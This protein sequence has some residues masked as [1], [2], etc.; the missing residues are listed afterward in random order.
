VL[1]AR[2]AA[3]ALVAVC[4]PF[5]RAQY[6]PANPDWNRPIEPFRIV[7]GLYYVGVQDVSSFL[8]TTQ[9]GHI[10]LDGAFRESAPLIEANVRKLGFRLEDVRLLL[11]SHGHCDHAGGLAELKAH[12]GARLLA[13]PADALLLARGG[14][15]D[16]AFHDTLPFPPVQADALLSDGQQVGLGGAVLTAHFTPGHTKGCTT[17]TATVGEGGKDY[18]VVIPCSVSAPGYKLVDNP[19]YPGILS[20]FE[21]TFATLRALPCDIFLG[22]H[23]WDFG[24]K[25]KAARTAPNA[26]VDPQGYLRYIE[27]G[28]AAV[29]AQA[30]KQKPR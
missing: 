2:A 21:T 4:A 28:Q 13:S 23:S 27:K 20:D 25:E 14:K 18:R 5:A 22:S 30:E 10:L 9:Q 19:A 6:A 1:A 3:I 24:L 15:D 26:F 29:R 8:F 11:N 16:F 12:T 17:W 7:G